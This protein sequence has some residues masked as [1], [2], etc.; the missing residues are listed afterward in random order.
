MLRAKGVKSIDVKV[1]ATK[2]IVLLSGFVDD[3]GQINR[4]GHVASGV[5]SVREVRNTLQVRPR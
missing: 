4:A 5:G 2:G 3:V 1:E